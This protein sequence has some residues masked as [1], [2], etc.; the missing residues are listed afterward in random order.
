MSFHTSKLRKPMITHGHV[1][2]KPPP[3]AE[4]PPH[5]HSHIIQT[6]REGFLK[7]LPAISS[8]SSSAVAAGIPSRKASKDFCPFSHLLQQISVAEYLGMGT[9]T[10]AK[11]KKVFMNNGTFQIHLVSETF[12]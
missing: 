2:K 8:S 12:F 11:K 4:T 7:K 6:D 9:S 1:H 5:T 10:N 3:P